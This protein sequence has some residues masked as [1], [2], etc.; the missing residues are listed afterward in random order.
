VTP[1][2][3]QRAVALEL[4]TKSIQQIQREAAET[5]AYRAWYEYRLAQN[6]P[7]DVDAGLR[8]YH[9]ATEY[10]H[11]ALEHAALCGDDAVIGVVRSIIATGQPG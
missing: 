9:D 6:S 8:A 3:H 7:D 5:W 11:E 2:E 10:E 1:E 4:S